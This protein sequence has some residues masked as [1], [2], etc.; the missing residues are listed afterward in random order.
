VHYYVPTIPL[1]KRELID[2][3]RAQNL[4]SV[5][6]VWAALAGGQEDPASKPALASLMAV[7]WNGAQIEERDARF[8]NDRVHGNIQKDGTFS[9]VPE[10]AGGICTSDELRR[11]AAVADKYQVP[12]IKLTGGQ[13]ID[14]VGVR[15]DDLPGVWRDLGM[16]AGSAWAKAYRTCKSCIGVEYCR[17]G[18]GDSMDLAV[19]VEKRFR[20]L[21]SPGKLKL[22]TAGCPRNCSEALV[23]DVGA[24]AVEGGKWELYVGGAAGAHVR[25]GDL[26]C[27]VDSHDDVLRLS[28]RFIQYYRENAKYKER[29]YTFV[30]RIGIERLRAI[31]VDDS[32]K[33]AAALDRAMDE[34]AAATRDPWLE[35]DEPATVNQFRSS[36]PMADSSYGGS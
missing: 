16:P 3:I 23:K 9:V 26:L 2:T 29:T 36:L 31:V 20:G 21:D 30:E 33:I 10:I 8:I 1:N 5:S 18:L 15:K 34:S 19:K 32:E 7:A 12:L 17:F 22:A 24:V 11:I 14:L 27:V 6:Q 28:G 35:R 4:R 25:K 13:R